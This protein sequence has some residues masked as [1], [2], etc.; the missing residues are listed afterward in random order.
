[1]C[2][3]YVAYKSILIDC[4]IDFILILIRLW[5]N[6]ASGAI[7]RLLDLKPDYPLLFCWLAKMWRRNC[8]WKDRWGVVFICSR[9]VDVLTA[10]QRSLSV[11]SRW[12]GLRQIFQRYDSETRFVV[13]RFYIDKCSDYR[14]FYRAAW[15]AHAVL[16]WEFC[17]S[18]RPSV[19][20]VDC[21]KTEE[22]YV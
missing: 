11:C 15:N 19:K 20:R 8:Y 18:V 10:R 14:Y 1:M 13:W 7:A 6:P 22:R 3:R 12:G 16:R 21:D 5:L 4:L 17:P 2:D 9:Q